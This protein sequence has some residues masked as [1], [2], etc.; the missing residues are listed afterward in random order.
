L[1]KGSAVTGPM[2]SK[3]IPTVARRAMRIST[4]PINRVHHEILAFMRFDA[5]AK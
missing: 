4:A 2:V 1:E 5:I 3:T